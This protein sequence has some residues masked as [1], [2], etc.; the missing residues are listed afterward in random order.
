MLISARAIP[1]QRVELSP[2]WRASGLPIVF[3]HGVGANHQLWAEWVLALAAH[4]ALVRFDMRGFGQ[5]P[6]LTQGGGDLL[7]ELI[8]DLLDVAGDE[9]RVHLVGESAGGTIALA[10]ALRHPERVASADT[11]NGNVTFA[12]FRS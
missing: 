12:T 9:G 5:A 6:P 7:G 3:H 4:H 8:A 10:A 1:Y 2:P 11:S